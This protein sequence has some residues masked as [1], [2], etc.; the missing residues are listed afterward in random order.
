MIEKYR[1]GLMSAERKKREQR[2]VKIYEVVFRE[3]EIRK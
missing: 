3:L 2:W 1:S